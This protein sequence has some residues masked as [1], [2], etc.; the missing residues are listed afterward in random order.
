MSSLRANTLLTN[1]RHANQSSLRQA[2]RRIRS[3]ES[4]EEAQSLVS[5]TSVFDSL[6][7][8]FSL[9]CSIANTAT[10]SK[11]EQ[12]ITMPDTTSTIRFMSSLPSAD[13]GSLTPSIRNCEGIFV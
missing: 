12:K 7:C 6:V 3:K 9:V 11:I 13:F 1:Q 5:S 10:Q 2:N 4:H 8:G